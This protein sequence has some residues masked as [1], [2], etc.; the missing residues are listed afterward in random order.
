MINF[1]K[2]LFRGNTGRALGG[3]HYNDVISADMM[4]GTENIEMNPQLAYTLSVVSSCV[5]LI[6]GAIAGVD[7]DILDIKNNK[8]KNAL[9]KKLN[10]NISVNLAKT[11]FLESVVSQIL[12]QGN[13]YCYIIKDAFGNVVN[14]YRFDYGVV[15]PC[16]YEGKLVYIVNCDNVHKLPMELVNKIKKYSLNLT[17]FVLRDFEVLNF[18]NAN[19]N[20]LRSPSNLDGAI[21]SLKIHVAQERYIRS[22]FL[23]GNH[24]KII[25]TRQGAISPEKKREFADAWEKS[26][27]GLENHKPLVID[28]ST[29]ITRL[30]STLKDNQMIEQRAFEVENIARAFRVPSFLINQEAKTTSFG[31]GISQIY[32]SFFFSTLEPHL[33]RLQDEFNRKLMGNSQYRIKLSADRF[34]RLSVKERFEVYEKAL[35]LGLMD[36]KQILEK[37]NLPP[38]ASKPTEMPSSDIM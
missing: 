23:K 24:E 32:D 1:F 3:Y 20:T 15:T 4:N 12:L 25:I 10:N 7:I 17:S 9:H 19:F 28:K 30:G 21:E 13:S 22:Y 5:S 2:G 36:K 33:N 27:S 35:E 31:S 6:S 26:Y 16:L 14:L 11:S 34:N 37:E 8:I 18:K 29:G 38:M